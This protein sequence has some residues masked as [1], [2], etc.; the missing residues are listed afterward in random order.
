MLDKLIRE[1]KLKK[2]YCSDLGRTQLYVVDSSGRPSDSKILEWELV[3]E[4]KR[5]NIWRTTNTYQMLW[6]GVGNPMLPKNQV[7]SL[8]SYMEC[9]DKGIDPNQEFLY[10]GS[11]NL[12]T[13][14]RRNEEM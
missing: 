5:F 1:G 3:E 8:Q 2:L 4:H 13:S 7:P 10:R 12:L 9:F 6:T 14:I 11:R